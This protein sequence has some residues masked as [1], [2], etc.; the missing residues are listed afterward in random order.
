MQA[1]VEMLSQSK[2]ETEGSGLST[3]FGLP[4]TPPADHHTHN[5]DEKSL[6]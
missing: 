6:A 5:F 1:H 4:P 3:I 2:L